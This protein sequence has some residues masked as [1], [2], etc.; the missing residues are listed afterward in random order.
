MTY[1][2]KERL[3]GIGVCV[4]K[5]SGEVDALLLLKENREYRR[6]SLLRQGQSEGR[7]R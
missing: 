2:G 7:W 1:G 6:K 5:M 3:E 4:L